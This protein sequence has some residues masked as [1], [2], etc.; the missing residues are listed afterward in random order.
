MSFTILEQVS[1]MSEAHVLVLGDP[2]YDVYHWGRVERISQEAPVPVFVGDRHEQRNGGALNVWANLKTLGAKARYI[3]PSGAAMPGDPVTEKHRFMVGHH[4]I[5]RADDDVQHLALTMEGLEE[6]LD[7]CH[8]VILADYGKGTLSHAF[9]QELIEACRKRD[10]HTLVDPR[11]ANWDKYAGATVVFP[12]EA[13]W[14]AHLTHPNPTR[15]VFPYIVHKRG[16]EG[17]EL[18]VHGEKFMSYPARARQVFDVTG[19]GDTV[20]AAFAAA[21]WNPQYTLLS[22]VHLANVAAGLVVA[23]VGTATV[24]NEELLNA[25]MED[26]HGRDPDQQSDPAPDP[27]E[28]QPA[29]APR[30]PG[31]EHDPEALKGH[32]YR[33]PVSPTRG[34]A[35]PPGEVPAA[36][37]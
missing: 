27:S 4:Q 25:V 37:E 16:A 26:D 23:K 1:R 30:E 34:G 18:R 28:A 32:R 12:N 17:M 2:I 24:S 29:G 10:K 31:R 35:A 13:E 22:A 9:C 5:F 21:T 3:W 14:V 7:W 19:A 36:G 33:D 20:I 6:H 15:P 8:N 11:G